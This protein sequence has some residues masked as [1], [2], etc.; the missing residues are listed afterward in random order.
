MNQLLL[1]LI[2]MLSILV[3]SC[4]SIQKEILVSSTLNAKDG[5]SISEN[6]PSKILII[7]QKDPGNGRAWQS[8]HHYSSITDAGKTLSFYQDC[9]NA[10]KEKPLLFFDRYL[11]GDDQAL[12]RMI[13]ALSHDFSAFGETYKQTEQVFNKS[14]YLIKQFM[15]EHK[16][17][18][19]LYNRAYDFYRVSWAQYDSWRLRYCDSTF[20]NGKVIFG[21]CS[22]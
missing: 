22:R 16:T 12:F 3:A 5:S 17:N 6:I 9:F 20:V 14:F 10:L 4:E 15:Q 11:A 19:E 2:V 21:H 7:L 8:L 18:R 13:D 1:Y